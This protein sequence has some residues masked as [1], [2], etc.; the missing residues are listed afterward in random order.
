MRTAVF[1]PVRL[2][3]TRLPKKALLRIKEKTLLEHLIDRVKTAKLPDLIVICTTTNPEDSVL[4]EIAQ[5]NNIKFFR[6]SEKD[7]VERLL[8]AAIKFNIDFVVNVDGD[9]VLCAP[10]FIDKT[11]ELFERTHA[12]FIGCKELPLGTSPCGIKVDALKNVYHIKNEADTETGWSRYFTE[13]G[14]FNVKYL[15]VNDEELKHPEIRM[16]LDYPE[17]LEFVQEIF[18]RLYVFGEIFTLKDI[19]TLLHEH[20]SIME[21][22]KGVQDMYWKNFEKHTKIKLKKNGGKT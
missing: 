6:G 16:T 4:T 10:E 11:I 1:I 5:K 12:D 14:L 17:D 15:D 18:T 20:P 21:L 8:K 7:I 9:D 3:S 13:T 2:A 19:L 22:N